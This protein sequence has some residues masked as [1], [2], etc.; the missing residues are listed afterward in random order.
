MLIQRNAKAF[1]AEKNK[2]WVNL[3]GERGGYHY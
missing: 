1:M 3:G 2:L